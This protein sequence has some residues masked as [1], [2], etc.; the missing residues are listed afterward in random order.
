MLQEAPNIFVNTLD[1]P[2]HPYDWT[3]GVFQYTIGLTII[4]SGLFALDGAALA[5]LS[6][7]S[8]PNIRSIFLN[9]GTIATFVGLTARLIANLQI[10]FVDLSHRLIN[11][12]IVNSVVVPLFL[13][14]LLLIH[15][16]RK[17][18]FFLM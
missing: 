14:S 13:A 1:R 11:S 16:V 2:S 18:F 12:D 9:L 15:V 3:L 17:H 5:L 6:K 4:V 8:P 7:T 10:L